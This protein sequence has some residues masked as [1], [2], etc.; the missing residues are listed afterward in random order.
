VG[1]ES[2]YHTYIYTALDA[3]DNLFKS[4][5]DR[6]RMARG[7]WEA[8]TATVGTTD[9]RKVNQKSIAQLPT[10]LLRTQL[11]QLGIQLEEHMNQPEAARRARIEHNLLNMEREQPNI[12]AHEAMGEQR[13]MTAFWDIGICE[14]NDFTDFLGNRMMIYSELKSRHKGS[15]FTGRHR[16][17][18]T[19]LC[20]YLGCEEDGTLATEY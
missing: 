19:L 9:I 11:A 6:G 14:L 7:I 12:K 8:Y 18:F 3:T 5:D 10:L 2:I 20:D 17:S 16:K 4:F 1:V 15:S 13:H